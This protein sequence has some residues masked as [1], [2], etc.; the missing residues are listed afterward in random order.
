[1]ENANIRVEIVGPTGL[2]YKGKASEVKAI[3][4]KGQVGILPN[5]A[6]YIS[7]LE[8]GPVVISELNSAQEKQFDAKSGLL[9]VNKNQVLILLD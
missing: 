6:E 9:S 1:M 8:E 4:T 3:S 5:H 2:V 7:L